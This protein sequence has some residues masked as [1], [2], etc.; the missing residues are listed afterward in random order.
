MPGRRRRRSDEP[1][2]AENFV[3]LR[4]DYAAAK[5][6]RFQRHRSGVSGAGSGADYHYRRESDHLRLMEYA[7]DMDRNDVIIGQTVDRAVQN[8]IQDGFVLDPT[9]G[10]EGLGKDLFARWTDWAEDP[11]QCDV[12][13][14]RTFWDMETLALRSPFIDGDILALPLKSSGALQLVEAHRLRTPRNTTRKNC[15]HGVLLDNLRRPLEYWLTK[16]NIDPMRTVNKVSDMIRIP[17]RDGEGNRQVFH[18]R[19]SKRVSQTRGVS[20]LAPIMDIAG[21]WEDLNF[22]NLVRAQVASCFAILRERDLAAS[23]GVGGN[24]PA[25][26][27][28]ETETLADGTTRTIEGIAPGMDVIGLPG[29]K[30]QMSSPNVPNPEFFPHCKMLLQLIGVNLGLPLVLV[31]LDAKET[32]FSGWR[33]AVDQARMGFRGNQKRLGQQ[34]HSPVYQWKLRQWISEDPAL[35]TAAERLGKKFFSHTWR[36]PTWPYIEPMKDAAA[37]LLRV[38]NALTSQRRRAAERGMDWDVLTDEIC[39]DNA[40]LIRKAHETA[41][42]LNE[43]NEGLGITWREVAALPTPDGVKVAVTA[44]AGDDEPPPAASQNTPPPPEEKPDA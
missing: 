1:T 16:D 38:R 3:A 27:S 42:K 30:L 40:K 37:D 35:R 44:T 6:S 43:D 5:G 14:E 2:T 29:E 31:L 23:A 28:T 8:T 33:G 20:A 36:P 15:V 39:A 10:D 17:A 22:A 26:G 12:A 32:N 11:G 25:T 21:M 7:R 41:V 34:F 9:T 18:I 19:V 13:G 4:A 24:T